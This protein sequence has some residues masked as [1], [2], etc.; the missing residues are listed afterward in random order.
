MSDEKNFTRLVDQLLAVKLMG[1]IVRQMKDEQPICVDPDPHTEVLRCGVLCLEDC[2]YEDA[3]VLS[4]ERQML[5]DR[6]GK[7]YSLI[8]DDIISVGAA[9]GVG[10]FD[11]EFG[12]AED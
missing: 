11:E 10:F 1:I 9:L 2:I 7:E 3:A 5:D 8:C 4:F 12:N 6:V